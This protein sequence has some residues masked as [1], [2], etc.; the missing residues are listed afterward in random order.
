MRKK[1]SKSQRKRMLKRG[2]RRIEDMA[3]GKV[4]GLTGSDLTLHRLIPLIRNAFHHFG[5]NPC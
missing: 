1:F 2:V 4:K 5:L 3:S